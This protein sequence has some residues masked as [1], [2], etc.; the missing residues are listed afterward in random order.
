MAICPETQRWVALR[1]QAVPPPPAYAPAPV[2]APTPVPLPMPVAVPSVADVALGP[3]SLRAPTVAQLEQQ[4]RAQQAKAQC[5]VQQ[6][7]SRISMFPGARCT[8][9]LGSLA[10][11]ESNFV[12]GSWTPTRSGDWSVQ[13]NAGMAQKEQADFKAQLA[14]AAALAMASPVPTPMPTP[15]GPPRTARLPT[16]MTRARMTTSVRGRQLPS[17]LWMDVCQARPVHCR[18]Q[19]WRWRWPRQGCQ[20]RGRRT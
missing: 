5:H 4:A 14:Q 2:P 11:A 7:R 13:G 20:R 9:L 10:S 19:C 18:R 1:G 12:D 8:S 17:S 15:V 16:A 3:M 6:L